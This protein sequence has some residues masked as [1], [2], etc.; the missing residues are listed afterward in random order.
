[1]GE[2]REN[3]VISLASGTRIHGAVSGLPATLR[4]GVRVFASGPDGYAAATG[5]AADGSFE[6]TGAPAGPI[7][8]H[9]TAGDPATSLRT[10]RTQVEIAEGEDEAQAQIV[11]ESGFSL[12]GT[13]T[14]N[15]Q[16]VDGAN[17]SASLGGRGMFTSARTSVS[18]AY[19]LEGLSAGT[20]DVM[21]SLEGGLGGAPRTQ[22]ITMEGDAT[23]DLVIPFARLGGVVVDGATHQPLA[24]VVVQATARTA[25]RGPR[26]AST[27]SNG[28]FSLEDLEA[29]SYTLV[30]R[31]SGY[32]LLSREVTAVEGGGDDLL[33]ELARGAGIALEVRD[34]SFGVPLRAV[35]ARATDGAGAVVFAG[36]VALDSEG[37]GEVPS[38]PP[39]SYALAVYASGYAPASLVVT[40]PAPPVLLPLTVGGGIEIRPGPATLESGS[41]RAQI[42]TGGGEPYPFAFFSPEGR[43]TLTGVRRLENLA[44]GAYVLRVDGVEPRPFEVRA[45]TLTALTLP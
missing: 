41:A 43:L 29:S 2:S 1:V 10:A 14:R 35:Q 21:V 7:D 13:V 27:D 25:A 33:V 20:Y 24:D 38:L 36:L 17:V 5:T 28:R 42:L 26:N 4:G 11:F 40:V 19:R 9:A 39:G 31:K 37:R 23:L 45:D 12:A 22:S 3:L 8:L 6:L 18:G 34:A 44:P 30:A 15:G 32:Q 16:P